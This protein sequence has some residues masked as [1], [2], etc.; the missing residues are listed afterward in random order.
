MNISQKQ[1]ILTEIET[2]QGFDFD[3]MIIS[4]SPE[5]TDLKTIMFGKYN[6]LEF[7]TFCTKPLHN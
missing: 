5:N 2:I 4:Q 7:K 3:Q 6:S 1:I